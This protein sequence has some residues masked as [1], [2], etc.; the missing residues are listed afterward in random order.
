DND[1]AVD[2]IVEIWEGSRTSA[3]A[4]DAPLA[5]SSKRPELWAGG[6]KPL[7]FVWNA[8]SKGYRLG[9][10][11]SSDHVST[12][13]SYTMVIAES[14]SREALIDAMRKRHTYAATRNI[15]LDYRMN[16]G[17]KTYLQGDDL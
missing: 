15:L 1:P 7:G 5:P 6:F 14:G 12:H 13:L 17:G 10:Q 9:V 3:E 2:P 16:V 11:A 8:W 4:E